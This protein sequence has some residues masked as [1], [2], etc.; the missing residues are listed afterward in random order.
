[1]QKVTK[2]GKMTLEKLANMAANGFEVIDKR[3]VELEHRMDLGFS[4]VNKRLDSHEDRLDE[5][6]FH[7][8]ELKNREMISE[9][10]NKQIKRKI[11]FLE[12]KVLVK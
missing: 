1:M 3:F 12:R 8:F 11:D 9:K 10:E 2:N 5:L 7:V 4:D 6:N